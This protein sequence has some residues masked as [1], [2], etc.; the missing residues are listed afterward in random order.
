MSS[1]SEWPLSVSPNSS[2]NYRSAYVSL[3]FIRAVSEYVDLHA[4]AYKVFTLGTTARE[5][6][7]LSITMVYGWLWFTNNDKLRSVSIQ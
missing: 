6:C 5:F 2:E 3:R 1:E 4:F 7:G